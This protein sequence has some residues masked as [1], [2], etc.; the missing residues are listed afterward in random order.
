MVLGVPEEPKEKI[1]SLVFI[2]SDRMRGLSDSIGSMPIASHAFNFR[3]FRED[4][5]CP[6]GAEP[7]KSSNIGTFGAPVI[8]QVFH[9]PLPVFKCFLR[10]GGGRGG[11]IACFYRLLF[12]WNNRAIEAQ[13]NDHDAAFC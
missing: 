4:S 6:F 8:L 5:P 3:H 7:Q 2:P 11:F 12:D 10:F 1:L 9:D 13:S